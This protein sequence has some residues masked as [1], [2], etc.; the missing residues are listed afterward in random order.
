VNGPQPGGALPHE[1]NV[2]PLVA[3]IHGPRS[4]D[5]CGREFYQAH[6]PAIMRIDRSRPS[7]WIELRRADKPETE[8]HLG[9]YDESTFLCVNVR[10]QSS[11]GMLKVKKNW[12]PRASHTQ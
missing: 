5:G 1:T 4:D 10:D 6:L 9:Q 12:T 3:E 2:I 11:P 8:G 7:L